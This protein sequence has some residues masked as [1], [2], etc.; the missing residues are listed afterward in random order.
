R[1]DLEQRMEGS[2]YQ[3]IR[4]FYDGIG[5]LIQNRIYNAEVNGQ[6]VLAIVN[7]AH[8][9]Y[10]RVTKQTTPFTLPLGTAYSADFSHPFTTTAYDVLGRP[11]NITA[12][13]GNHVSYGY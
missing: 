7:Y 1:I 5:R 4:K 12:P 8:D 11:T 13:N 10:G 9:A 2:N 6:G 3:I